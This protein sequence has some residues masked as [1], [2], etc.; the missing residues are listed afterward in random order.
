[1]SLI[2][3]LPALRSLK[4]DLLP[5]EVAAR[6]RHLPGTV[7]F[8]AALE[9]GDPGRVSIVA[10]EPSVV[11]EG[12]L[13]R[14]FGKLRDAVAARQ[15]ET[16]DRGIPSGFAAGWIEYDG[17]FCFGFYENALIYRH[18]DDAWMEVGDF[19][20]RIGPELP[21]APAAPIAFKS[22]LGG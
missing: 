10:A 6:C 18:A 9:T 16:A 14:D 7:F 4:L 17:R 2:F 13:D 22:A 12:S 1:M 8:D 19:A 11:L 15:A 20:S 3:H 5:V 21:A